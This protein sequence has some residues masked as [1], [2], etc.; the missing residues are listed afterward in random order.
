[1]KTKLFKTLAIALAFSTLTIPAMAAATANPAAAVETTA[2]QAK[3]AVANTIQILG[4]YNIPRL[5]LE[6]ENV[7]P[8][9]YKMNANLLS[10]GQVHWGFGAQEY[11]RVEVKSEY[12]YTVASIGVTGEETAAK[13]ASYL[14]GLPLYATDTIYVYHKESLDR[15]RVTGTVTDA[16]RDLSTGIGGPT[17][18][19]KIGF[20]VSNLNLRYVSE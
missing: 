17:Y 15:L 3:G 14:N 5:T 4:Y 10:T 12:G 6:I 9:W 2:P 16:P 20:K 7:D 13:A 11:F 18:G 8:Y 1:M 19:K